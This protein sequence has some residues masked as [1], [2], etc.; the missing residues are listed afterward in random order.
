MR[1]PCQQVHEAWQVEDFQAI[2]P[3]LRLTHRLDC[4]LTFR[5]DLSFR[6]ATQ[7]YEEV[8]DTFSLRGEIDPRFPT[9]VPLIFETGGRIHADFHTNP[10]GD[11]CLGS[12]LGLRV[13]LND[14]PT[15]S[16]FIEKL[17]IPFLYN[18]S[19]YEIHGTMPLGEL[20]HG[21]PGLVA[22]YERMFRVEGNNNCVGMLQLLG[23]KKRLANKRPCPCGSGRRLGKCHNFVLNPLRTIESRSYFSEQANV[24]M[25][26]IRVHASSG[27]PTISERRAT[28]V[29]G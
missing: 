8:G 6:A 15:L 22:D 16:G 5:G 29:D 4:G 28:A 27:K 24:L 17:V 7:G 18:Y 14:D 25:E 3:A 21:A 11:L 13:R 23:L 20:A 9:V 10:D 1:D 12:P 26:Q 19:H 2:Y